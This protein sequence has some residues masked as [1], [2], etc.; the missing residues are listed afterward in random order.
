MSDKH[1]DHDKHHGHDEHDEHREID[2]FARKAGDVVE[3]AIELAARGADVVEDAFEK[4]LHHGHKHDDDDDERHGGGGGGG[5][6][7]KPPPGRP[8]KVPGTSRGETGGTPLTPGDFA[9]GTPPWNSW[10][11]PRKDLDTPILVMRANAGDKGA[12]PVVGHFWESP[13]ILIAAGV[14]PSAA[15]EIPSA[16]G[17]TAKAGQHNTVY[18]HVWNWG[19]GPARFVVVEFWWANPTLGI[20]AAGCQPIGFAVTWLAPVGQPMSHRIVKCPESWDARYVNG[21]HEC[22]VVRFYDLCSSDGL[23]PPVWDASQ[24]RHVAQRNIHVIA[25]SE[26]AAHPP[27]TLT[28]GPLFGAPATV[29]VARVNPTDMHWLQLHTM[30]RGKFPAAAPVT[31]APHLSPP[32]P[33]GTAPSAGTGAVHTVNGDDQGVA[34]GTTDAPPPPGQAHVYRVTGTQGGA[35]IGGYTVVVV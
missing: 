29:A 31:G 3:D 13:D 7:G 11:G 6:Y 9:G 14:K 2:R 8:Q 5:G 25:A 15:P 23:A 19:L 20:N 17:A 24:N 1:D 34:F 33:L 18:A 27:I 28:V 30:Q 12:R 32:A 16:L 4:L 35:T 21:G 10:P 22:L 26:L